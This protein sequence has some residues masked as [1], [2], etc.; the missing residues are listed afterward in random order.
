MTKQQEL[1]QRLEEL[2]IQLGYEIDYKNLG[3]VITVD[4]PKEYE[5]Y[6]NGE[7]EDYEARLY[8]GQDAPDYWQGKKLNKTY[9]NEKALR[10][11]IKDLEA[12]LA[13][14]TVLDNS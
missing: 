9:E 10:E 13:Q 12:E 2:V 6:E 14:R 5:A 4:N 7:T 3:G 8:I 11:A 1:F